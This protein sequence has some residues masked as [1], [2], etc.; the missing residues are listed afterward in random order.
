MSSLASESGL[1][2]RNAK[3][4]AL[5]DQWVLFSESEILGVTAIFYTALMAKILP[6]YT[7]EVRFPDHAFDDIL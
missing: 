7:I 6:G 5:V 4:A 2:G 1:L 3:E